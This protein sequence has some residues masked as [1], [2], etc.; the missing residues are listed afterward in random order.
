[1]ASPDAASRFEVSQARPETQRGIREGGRKG[2]RAM[3]RSYV[4]R[5]EE[6]LWLPVTMNSEPI[7]VLPRLYMQ[8]PVFNPDYS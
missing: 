7:R 8:M 1:M 6:G 2:Y 5:A 3:E 4:S